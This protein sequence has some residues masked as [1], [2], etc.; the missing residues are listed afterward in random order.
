MKNQKWFKFL[1]IAVV[2]IIPFMYSF[3]YLKAY[4]NPYG[5]GNID[6]LPVAIV[7]SDK[8]DKGDDLIQSIKDSKKLKIS[9]VSEKKANNGLNDGTYYAV[10]NIPDDFTSSME[11][12]SSEDKHHATITYSPNQKSNYLSS[13]I[14]NTV[15]L[16]VEKNLDNKVNSQIVLNLTEKLESVP[17]Q[18]NTISDGFEELSNGTN[19]LEN[20]AKTLKSGTNTLNENYS[21]FNE[22]VK[23]VSDGSTTLSNAT[24]EFSTLNSSIDELVNG[25]DALNQGASY[26]NQKTN[27]Y[28]NGTNTVIGSVNNIAAGY[29]NQ[30][31]YYAII[32]QKV[33]A[34]AIQNGWDEAT[35]NAIIAQKKAEADNIINSDLCSSIEQLVTNESYKTLANSGTALVAGTQN[36]SNNLN[37]LNVKVS[38]FS[39]VKDKLNA[40]QSGIKSLNQGA[41]KLY[42]SSLQIQS[43]ISELN[44]GA[45]TL[46]EGTTTLNSSVN[47][48]KVELNSK[49]DTTKAELKKLDGLDKYSEEPIKV[50]TT[51]VNEIS[52]YGTAFAPLFIS[53]ALWV[54][55]LMM[56][57]ILYYDKDERFGVLGINS[58]NRIKRT[59]CY[60]VLAT[61][62]GLV[63]GILLQMLLDFE[64]TNVLLYYISIILISNCFLAIMQF[65]IGNFGDIGKFV[66]LIILVLQLAAAGGTFPIETVTKGFRFLN[67]I[68]PMT[69]TIKLLKESLV[70]IEGTLLTKNLLIV[71]LLLIILVV[72]NVTMDIIRTKKSK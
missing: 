52:S 32:E 33:N 68:L 47:N 21:L 70:S 46:S 69:Y 48:A 23:Q 39:S 12:I 58:E 6:N 15:V 71:S 4:W 41:N 64:I 38:G 11:S 67:P 19:Q 61:L 60:H 10:I 2:L 26:L 43:G 16:T 55:S 20:G 17:E 45:T 28:V 35:K 31:N 49:I 30:T 63:L 59:I 51:P 54:G 1:V 8:G 50:E 3:F 5:E 57:I 53:I 56:F 40:L 13:Q 62:S 14:I 29:C 42:T 27:E 24:N 65:L 9:V 72:I 36:L 22:G 18:L 7:N 44:N 25:V 34:L 66:G 37:T